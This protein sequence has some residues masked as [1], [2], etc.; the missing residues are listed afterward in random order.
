[1]FKIIFL[2]LFVLTFSASMKLK[3]EEKLTCEKVL[4]M[5]NKDLDP[6]RLF[7]VWYLQYYSQNAYR[8]GYDCAVGIVKSDSDAENTVKL[9]EGFFDL[10]HNIVT[11]ETNFKMQ[12]QNTLIYLEGRHKDTGLFILDSDYDNFSISFQC[13]QNIPIL[14]LA[15]KYSEVDNYTE[16]ILNYTL[17]SKLNI[18]LKDF[19]PQKQMCQSESHKVLDQVILN[20]D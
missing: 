8:P 15:T 3:A 17:L 19:V 5:A 10:K 6:T 1:M 2:C 7:G 14:I 11:K 9:L 20:L 12:D 18:S 4:T 13:Y 16:A